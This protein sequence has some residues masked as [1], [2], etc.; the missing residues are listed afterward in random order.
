M[1]DPSTAEQEKVI[2][3][4]SGMG[5]YA[6]L[7]LAAKVHR[8]TEARTDQE[9]LS[10]ALLSFPGRIVDRS[11]YLFDPAQPSPVPALAEIARRLEEAGAVVAGMPCNTAHGPAIF[12]ALKKE[13]RRTGHQLRFVHM[14]E[15]TAA[16]IRR[17]HPDLERVG[18]LS[19]Q[20]VY[21]LRLYKDVLDA[22]GFTA[23]RPSEEMQRALVNPVIFHTEYGIK[24]QSDP[25]TAR[26]RADLLKAVAALRANR[27][28]AVVLG[29]TEFPLALPGAAWEGLPLIDPTAVLARALIRAVA[30]DK[31]K[32]LAQGAAA[33]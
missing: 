3:I 30:P 17:A 31:L 20:A 22:A 2:G 14:L 16:H 24:A 10:V 23:V 5:P 11:T 19:S 21:A 9:H 32:P 26:A 8:F 28:E 1:A 27:A 25:V 15:A 29:C 18:V 12:G 7:D 4:L 6:G 33:V 13:L